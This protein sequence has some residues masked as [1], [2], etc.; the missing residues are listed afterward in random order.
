M[1]AVRKDSND[2]VGIRAGGRSNITVS[3]NSTVPPVRG[4]EASFHRSLLRVR[5][6][7]IVGVSART[8]S[9]LTV[10]SGAREA[11]TALE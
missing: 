9:R 3:T 2:A 10:P 4:R 5:S 8:V 6:S 7:R 11:R 1:I